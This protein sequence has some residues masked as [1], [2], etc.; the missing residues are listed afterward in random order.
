[1]TFTAK[2]VFCSNPNPGKPRK[3]THTARNSLDLVKS[4]PFAVPNYSLPPW[5]I[6]SLTFDYFKVNWKFNNQQ[7]LSFY[8][9]YV[10]LFNKGG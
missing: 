9:H 4:V 6:F 3:S 1:M 8:S 2:T 7:H 10:C 5:R